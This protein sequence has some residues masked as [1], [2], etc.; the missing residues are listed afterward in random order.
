MV[1]AIPV[2]DTLNKQ[3]KDDKSSFGFK[4]LQKMGWKENTGLGKDE[5]GNVDV[6]RIKKREE[7]LGLGMESIGNR[8][9]N[10]WG[11]TT[12]SFASV[13]E[14]LKE[15]FKKETNHES[16]KKKKSKHSKDESKKEDKEK[17]SKL[18]GNHISVGMK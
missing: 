5:I 9:N 14:S 18:S 4:L 1:E 10:N 17:G 6:I 12:A 8:A 11:A 16:K 2:V 13:L 7:G 15:N 3:W